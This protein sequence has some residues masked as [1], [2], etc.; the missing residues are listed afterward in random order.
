M[1]IKEASD[2]EQCSVRLIDD[3]SRRRGSSH[4]RPLNERQP[5][6]QHS[7]NQQG[8][9]R[10]H[11]HHGT[12]NYQNKPGTYKKTT[13]PKKELEE[14]NFEESNMRFDKEKL[15]EELASTDEH[16]DDHEEDDEEE[17]INGVQS[18]HVSTSYTPS[19]SFFDNISCESLDKQNNQEGKAKVT[20]HDQR[21]LD[22]ETFGISSVRSHDH[23][24]GGRG[25]N[26]RYNSYNNQNRQQQQQ[27]QPQNK[28]QQTTA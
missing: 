10:H 16:V 6:D 26:R 21:K 1:E 5:I 9:Q 19:K 25:Q 28:S 18:I 7:P 14:F 11:H 4:W 27:Q 20:L 15:A 23:R 24:R 2:V 3:R 13:G 8:Q 17:I 12:G 22:Q